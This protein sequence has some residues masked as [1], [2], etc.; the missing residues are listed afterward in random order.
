M[1][2]LRQFEA[3]VTSLRTG[4]PTRAIREITIPVDTLV[5]RSSGAYAELYLQ[6]N[7]M[8]IST[9]L[10]LWN[11][12]ELT[13]FS[14]E[15]ETVHGTRRGCIHRCNDG[16]VQHALCSETGEDISNCIDALRGRCG[17]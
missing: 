16:A 10:Q 5:Q 1:M 7:D 3:L 8:Q 13:A 17:R 12:Q 6:R 14:V 15:V 11:A 9:C 4:S 2:T